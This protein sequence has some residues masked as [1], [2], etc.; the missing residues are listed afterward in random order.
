MDQRREAV[1]LQP[2]L[3]E[4]RHVAIHLPNLMGFE[5]VVEMLLEHFDTPDLAGNV[6]VL[7]DYVHHPAAHFRERYP[8]RR[9]II[10][11]LE[12]MV[13]SV[14]W[15]SVE[16]VIEHLKGADERWDYDPLNVTFLAWHGVTIDRVVPMLYTERLRRLPANSDPRIDVL[17]GGSL[18]S[19]RYRIIEDVQRW[20]YGRVNFQWI[21]GF[22]GP[23]FD[24]AVADAKIILNL[25]AFEPWHRQEQTRIFY[26]LINGRMV[27]SETSETNA[28]GD[29][30]IEAPPEHLGQTILHW[31]AEDRWR[32]F[33]PAASERYRIASTRWLVENGAV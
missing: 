4:G 19:R 16:T 14:T 32:E 27:V 13:G 18:N 2:G 3:I 12:Q 15:H 11:Q 22:N 30:I 10:Y 20:F 26:P 29:C 17:F 1:V 9:I 31:L 33:G 21:F 7:G 8:G 24:R 5:Q 23:D 28:F 25:H 6:I